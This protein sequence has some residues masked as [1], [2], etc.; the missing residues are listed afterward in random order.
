MMDVIQFSY[1]SLVQYVTSTSMLG[2]GTCSTM[3]SCPRLALDDKPSL[4]R[5]LAHRFLLLGDSSELEIVESLHYCLYLR[6]VLHVLILVWYV[7]HT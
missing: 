4:L 7:S 3:I 2:R 5:A 1:V 6:E